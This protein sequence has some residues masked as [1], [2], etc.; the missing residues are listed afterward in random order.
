ML[1]KPEIILFFA[2][3][4]KQRRIYKYDCFFVSDFDDADSI[5]ILVVVIIIRITIKNHNLF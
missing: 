5:I 4:K 1:P 2:Q 3:L